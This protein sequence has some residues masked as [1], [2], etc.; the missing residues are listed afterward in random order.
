MTSEFSNVTVTAK[1][2][3]YFDGKVVS[4]SVLLADGSKKTVGL[5]YPGEY[6]FSTGAPETMEIIAGSCK[7]RL[8]GQTGTREYAA[9]SSFDVPG[10]SG[11]NISVLGGITEYVCSFG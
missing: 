11:F 10:K 9:G 5:I 7:V 3:V 6:H 4:H 2:N 8:D 1:A